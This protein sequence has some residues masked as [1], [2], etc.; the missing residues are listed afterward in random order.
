LLR[1]QVVIDAALEITKETGYFGQAH[2]LDAKT[3]EGMILV[4]I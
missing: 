4:E 1:R 2:V 3:D